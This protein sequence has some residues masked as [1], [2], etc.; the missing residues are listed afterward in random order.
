MRGVMREES[1]ARRYLQV[2]EVSSAL[3]RGRAVEC[4]LGPCGTGDDRGIRWLSLRETP[5]GEICACV[6]ESRDEGSPEFLDLYEFSPL[7]GELEL[8]EPQ[9]RM[10]FPDLS[11]CL[12]AISERWP[13]ATDRMVNQDVVQDEYADFI[14]RGRQHA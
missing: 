6:F 12:A 10:M 9:E 13:E 3:R 1:M 4:F 8:G 7:R 14:A 2:D 5:G 11:K